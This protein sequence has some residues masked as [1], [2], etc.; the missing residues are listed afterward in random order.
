VFIPR[1]LFADAAAM[2]SHVDD[3]QNLLDILS[4]V[5]RFLKLLSFTISYTYLIALWKADPAIK[6][7]RS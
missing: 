3:G 6:E 1:G 2:A 7:L 5:A 4:E